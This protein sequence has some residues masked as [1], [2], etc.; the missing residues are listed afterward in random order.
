M[1]KPYL[2]RPYAELQVT[3]HFSFLRGASDPQELV[4]QAAALGLSAIAITD[5]NTLAGVVRAYH[6][7][8]TVEKAGSSIRLIVGARLNFTDGPSVLTLPTDRQAYGHLSHLLT[9]GKRRALKGQC[10]LR[11]SDLLDLER[12]QKLI[13]VPPERLDRDFAAHVRSLGIRFPRAT[14]LAIH[15]HYGAHDRRRLNRLASIAEATRVPLVATNDVH[16]HVTE[17]RPLQDVM[18]CIREGCRLDEAGFRLHANAERHLKSPREM[19]RL[20]QSHPDALDRTVEIAAECTFSLKELKYEY[21]DEPV[22]EGRTPQ[23]HLTKLTWDYAEEK[24]PNGIPE[25]VRDTLKKEL[26]LIEKLDYARYFLTIHEIVEVAREKKI[27]CQGRGSAAN[28]A[29]CYVLGITAVDPD[30]IDVLFDRFMSLDRNDEPPDIDVDFEHERREEIIQWIYERYGRDRAGIVATTITYRSKSAM[31]DVA[32][33]FGLSDRLT[34]LTHELRGRARGEEDAWIADPNGDP[35]TEQALA[36]ADTLRGFPRHLSQHTGGF[37]ITRGPLSH[38]VPIE[39]A[40]MENRTVIEWNKDDLDALGMLKI[41][42]LALGML[43][44]LRKGLDLIKT[45]YG[46]AF[47]LGQITQGTE[48]GIYEMLSQAD[49]VGLFQVESRAQMSMLPRLK[50]REFYDLVVEVAI[51]RPGP[52]QG[53]MVHPYLRR[54]EGKEPVEMPSEALREVLKRTHGVPLFQEQAM[55]IAMVAAG[56]TSEEASQLRSAMATFRHRGTIGGLKERFIEGMVRNDYKR[57]FAERCFR[58][59]EGFGDYGFPESHAASFALLVYASAWLKYH[60]PAV[61]TCAIL[62]SQPMGF[63]QPAQLV[64]DA[65]DRG[66]EVRPVDVSHSD[67]D[68]T[69][70]PKG[71][72]RFALRLGMRLLKGLREDTAKALAQ[73][74]ADGDPIT[75]RRLWHANKLDARAAELLG[76]GDAWNS[77]GLSRREALWAAKG[78]GGRPLPLFAPREEAAD[79]RPML[80]GEEVTEDYAHLGLSLKGHPMALLRPGLETRGVMRNKLLGELPNGSQVTLAGV[81]LIRQRPGTAKGVIFVTIEDETGVANLV[82]WPDVIERFERVIMDSQ[83]MEATG[84]V[85]RDDSGLVIHVVAEHIAD[86]SD[87]LI[88]ASRHAMLH[89]PPNEDRSP[90][91]QRRIP[92]SRDFH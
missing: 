40:A 44:C 36:L 18:T 81:V 56:F 31:R 51:V 92:R 4:V 11:F 26:V 15:Q 23:E 6:A 20:F 91:R 90:S 52:I 55:K 42:V 43:T 39:N 54:R 5:R 9:V 3:S 58:Q 35:R 46:H 32:K 24:Y 53:D 59:I 7:L 83:V 84:R 49:T 86:R 34:V 41:D 29:V 50:P 45:H 77:L 82:L 85:Q 80:L 67:W 13:V 30:K 61:F 89:R 17:R 47:Q 87:A 21:P 73:A 66:V 62:N 74:R 57:D 19:S 33:V 1:G 70:E 76:H 48:S 38:V 60:Y 28:S 25:K 69:L 16:A 79:L 72:G 71:E 10:H 2:V 14:Y 12:G 64:R 68:C 88:R 65:Q 27:L 37:V 75:L 22:P 8:K 78:L 63:Y